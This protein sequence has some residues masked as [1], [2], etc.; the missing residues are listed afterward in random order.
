MDGKTFKEKLNDQGERA[1]RY[2]K[3]IFLFLFQFF[4]SPDKGDYEYKK[5]K[6]GTNLDYS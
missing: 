2:T 3:E 5:T 4:F 6:V 1:I